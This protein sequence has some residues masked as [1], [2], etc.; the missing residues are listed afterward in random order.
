[1]DKSKA[2]KILI[3]GIN[4]FITKQ[5]RFEHTHISPKL[6][7]KIDILEINYKILEWFDRKICR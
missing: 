5:E 6:M 2:K 4:F 3:S 7:T 1:M